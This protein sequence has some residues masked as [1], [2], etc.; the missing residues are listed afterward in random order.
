MS[1]QAMSSIVNILFQMN[2]WGGLYMIYSMVLSI[3]TYMPWLVNKGGLNMKVAY[4]V[5][6]ISKQK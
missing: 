5:N 1:S 2:G 3:L 4:P 6:F